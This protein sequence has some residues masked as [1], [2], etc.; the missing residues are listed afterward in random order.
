MELNSSVADLFID[1]FLLDLLIERFL[2]LRLRLGRLRGNSSS[3]NPF[4]LPHYIIIKQPKYRRRRANITPSSTTTSIILKMAKDE[5]KS[6]SR[7]TST[8]DRS[9]R[10]ARV[11]D[12]LNL[13]SQN[14]SDVNSPKSRKY[15]SGSAS[16]IRST[17]PQPKE[18]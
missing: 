14:Y 18:D 16:S 7:S 6:V 10:G 3:D 4:F 2:R 17:I 13:L 9:K 12:M 8:S 11:E 1:I 5:H 15:S